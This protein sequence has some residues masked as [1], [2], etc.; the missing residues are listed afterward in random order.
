M[1]AMT[2]GHPDEM[3][4][5]R[6]LRHDCGRDIRPWVP[7]GATRLWYERLFLQ[8]RQPYD[9]FLAVADLLPSDAW[10]RHAI[11]CSREA[12]IGLTAATPGASRGHIALMD[13]HDTRALAQAA[14]AR[15]TGAP[16]GPDQ[17]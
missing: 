3:T 13:G 15:A 9:L 2:S 7:A 4:A 11:R 14:V 12:L 16:A 1:T 8:A 17:S 5:I 6:A 10:S